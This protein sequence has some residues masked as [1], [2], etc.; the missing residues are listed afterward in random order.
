LVADFVHHPDK[1]A[2]VKSFLDGV[3]E[4][5]RCKRTD[6]ERLRALIA[7]HQ[8]VREHI[9]TEL[10]DSKEVWDTLLLHTIKKRFDLC[11]LIRTIILS[12]WCGFFHVFYYVANDKAYWVIFGFNVC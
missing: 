2:E 7:E 1:V 10:L 12:D 5:K 3:E 8:L 11:N 6:I 9:P 4:A